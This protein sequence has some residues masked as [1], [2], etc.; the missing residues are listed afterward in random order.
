MF[1]SI[2][3]TRQTQINLKMEVKNEMKKISNISK[4]CSLLYTYIILEGESF[5]TLSAGGEA[6]L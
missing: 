6:P 2:D 1:Q 3:I 4:I 5:E